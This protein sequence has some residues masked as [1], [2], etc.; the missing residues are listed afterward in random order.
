MYCS[1]SLARAG[2]C[3]DKGLNSAG[4]LR[5]LDS[6]GVVE[7]VERSMKLWPVRRHS[8]LDRHERRHPLFVGLVMAEAITGGLPATSLYTA[9][10][11]ADEFRPRIVGVL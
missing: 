10:V 1:A 8:E 6:A 11:G 9:P 7:D 3:C 2:L 5:P 4:L